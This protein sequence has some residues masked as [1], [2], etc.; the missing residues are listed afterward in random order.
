MQ[1]YLLQHL[2]QI[3]AKNI[4]NI[5]GPILLLIVMHAILK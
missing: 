5:F 2:L 3:S 4:L 1:Q